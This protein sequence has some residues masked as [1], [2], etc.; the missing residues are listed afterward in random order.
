MHAEDNRVVRGEVLIFLEPL[1]PLVDREGTE[2][3]ARS[4]PGTSRPLHPDVAGESG[5]FHHALQGLM[6]GAEPTGV[7]LDPTDREPGLRETGVILT[8]GE[9]A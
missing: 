8:V 4:D 1:Q 7:V 2:D 9:Q 6:A 3:V 5:V